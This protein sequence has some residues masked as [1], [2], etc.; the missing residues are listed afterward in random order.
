MGKIEIE[1]FF[2]LVG[3]IIGIVLVNSIQGPPKTIY[4]YPTLENI[5]KTTYIDDNGVCYRYYAEP[6]TQ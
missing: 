6:L 2:V 3:F 4:I 1:A 5:D